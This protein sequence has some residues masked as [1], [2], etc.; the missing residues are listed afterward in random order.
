MQEIFK[1]D[2]ISYDVEVK[3]LTR[4]FD[5]LDGTKAGR[6]INGGMIRDII[7]T[8][9]NYEMDLDTSRMNYTE[10][11]NLY[12]RL[13]A[14]QDSHHLEIPYGQ[15][16][17]EFEAYVS[18]GSDTLKRKDL[19]GTWWEGLKVKFVAMEPQRRP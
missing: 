16:M 5:I 8:Y 19:N 1:I 6:A 4:S 2:G 12:E 3:N 15:S 10:Y 11:D 13:S 18:S 14:P 17:L 7:G 9:Y